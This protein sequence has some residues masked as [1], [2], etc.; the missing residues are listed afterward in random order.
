MFR[1]RKK[2]PYGRIRGLI[3]A[4][5]MSAVAMI[6]SAAAVDAQS[7]PPATQGLAATSPA[8]ANTNSANAGDVIVT[9][10]KHDVQV[11][12]VAA[13]VSVVT[14][15]QLAAAGPI[16]NTGDLLATVPGARFNNL[17]SPIL[18]EISMRG[19]GTERATGADPA[20]G[21]FSNGA[22]VGGGGGY[23]RNLSPIDSFDLDHIEVLAGPQGALYGRNAEYGAVNLISAQPSFRDTGY[24]DDSYVFQTKQ[25]QVTAVVNHPITDE[26]AVR[27]GVQNTEQSGGFILN[28]DSN[29]YYDTTSGWEGRAQVRVKHDNWDVD[30]LAETEDLHLP[31][32][33][34]LYDIPGGGKYPLIP[35]GYTQSK[36]SLPENG[37]NL[38]EEKVNDINLSAKYDFGWAT[39]T[40]TSMARNRVTTLDYDADYLDIAAEAA[41]QA[42][43]EKGAYPFTQVNSSTNTTVLYEDLH[44]VGTSFGDRLNWVVGGEVMQQRNNGVGT[45]AGNPC[46]TN[47]APNLVVGAGICGGTPTNH[48]CYLMTPTSTPCPATYPSVFGSDTLTGEVYNSQAAYAS[49][50]YKIGYGFTL[51]GDLRYTNDDKTA[52]SDVYA[53]YTRNP[54]AFKTGG[55]VTDP[56]N[57]SFQ[58]GIPTYTA[59]LSYKIPNWDDMIY[60]KVGT[61]YRAGGFNYETSPPL[62]TPV[63]IRK[64]YTD[65]TNTSYEVGFKGNLTHYVY[66]TIDGYTST[67]ENALATVG[68]GCALT[69]ACEQAASA[70]VVNGGTSRASGIEAELNTTLNVLG[71][72]LNL[73]A[74]GS[75][76][77][78]T[79]ISVPKTFAG[80]PIVG[81]QVA[82][83]PHWLAASTVNYRHP[84]GDFLDGF[85][86]LVYHGQWGGIQD[87]VTPNLP[88]QKL[89]NFN[90]VDLR[91][92]VD[93]K[94]FEFAFVAKNL[95]NEAYVLIQANQAVAGPGIVPVPLQARWNLPRTLGVEAK[96]KW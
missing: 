87:T 77:T 66:F 8:N 82:Q 30:L 86:N 76:Q 36:Y 33:A 4:T 58:K 56:T 88:A 39:L 60:A 64:S 90:N 13:T 27:L 47:A 38:T 37:Q 46:A 65:E 48:I 15:A 93:Y 28:P 22:F 78:A 34:T 10:T 94:N 31:S 18:S 61:G 71:G 20:I 7:A 21:L 53:L 45:V 24:I 1:Y 89:S 67:T 29:T 59:T 42:Q 2:S 80:L 83:T 52:T 96:Y 72:V 23:G 11:R 26:I 74:D 70:F 62:V 54:F 81:T 63:P 17:Q 51:A 32:F 6:G 25:N 79:Y 43:N 73:E 44:L 40:S 49:L 19:S 3:A 92:G 12:K 35:N 95:T 85:V 84:I 5:C 14:G 41:L 91:T 68:D 75:T 9:A 57:Y 16:N 50:S 69:N 55:T